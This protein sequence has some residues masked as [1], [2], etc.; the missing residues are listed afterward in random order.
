MPQVTGYMHYT[1]PPLLS[2]ALPM[3]ALLYLR[4]GPG[5]VKLISKQAD[6]HSFEVGAGLTPGGRACP[7][8]PLRA[9]GHAA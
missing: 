2:F 3:S 5:G 9:S 6:F 8:Q 1:V 4:D 7:A